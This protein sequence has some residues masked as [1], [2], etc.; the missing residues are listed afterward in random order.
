M[1][2][3]RFACPAT[4][5]RCYLTHL[6]PS[7]WKNRPLR[8]FPGQFLERLREMLA[9]VKEKDSARASLHEERHEGRVG[10]CRIAIA[11]G[12]DKVV[13]AVIGVLAAAR[14]DVIERDGLG[15][16]LDSAVGADGAVFGEEPLAVT[17]V[18]ATGGPAKRRGSDRRCVCAGVPA[19]SGCSCHKPCLKCRTR[20]G[21]SGP[22][23]ALSIQ[24]LRVPPWTIPWQSP[25][26]GCPAPRPG[27]WKTW[28]CK[29][30]P[31]KHLNLARRLGREARVTSEP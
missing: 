25:A 5:P 4:L 28:Y 11:T 21:P 10:F 14:T 26:P 8:R 19:S 16:R 22:P 13:G 29:S 18:G 3:L 17:G 7:G 20:S 27:S 2:I 6:Q 31:F 1:G 30:L 9:V 12:Q 23:N 15:S 24:P